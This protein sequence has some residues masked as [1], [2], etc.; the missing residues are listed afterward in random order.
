MRVLYTGKQEHPSLL[1]FSVI[2]IQK[3]VS[4]LALRFTD[5]ASIRQK[6]KSKKHSWTL[7][8][9]QAGYRKVFKCSITTNK[10]VI[11][12]CW[13]KVGLNFIKCVDE[14]SWEVIITI[15]IITSPPVWGCL[16]SSCNHGALTW[17]AVRTS[18]TWLSKEWVCYL[19]SGAFM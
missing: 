8:Q 9:R 15:I 18:E 5:C 4:G 1:G 14:H 11:T 16:G 12:Q 10:A 13:Q 19:C 17:S 6:N 7:W 2:S 3:L